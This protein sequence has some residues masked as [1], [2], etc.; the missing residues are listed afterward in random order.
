STALAVL[1]IRATGWR[2]NRLVRSRTIGRLDQRLRERGWIAI[3]SLRFIPVVPFS[4]INYAAGA[5]A[6][7]VS[8]YMGA[9]LAGLLPGTVA[10]VI[11]GNAFAG[12][13]TPL[14]VVVSAFTAA[15]GLCG[16]VYEIRHYR[17]QHAAQA[18][19][20]APQAEPAV[21]TP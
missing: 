20:P 1:L 2:L 13:G 4:A 17:Q 10:V 8:P 3:L 11:L 9:T 16:L 5:S 15:L 7:R 21:V 19:A 18:S 12:D 6:V 14:L